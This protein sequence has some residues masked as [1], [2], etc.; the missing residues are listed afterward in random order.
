M[1]RIFDLT[2]SVVGLVLLSPFLLVI[3]V[4]IRCS[5]GAP[6]FFRQKRPG[7]KGKPFVIY[8]FRT[9]NDARDGAGKLL[10]DEKR[11]N[12]L[13]VLLRKTSLDE[14]PELFNVLWGEMSLVG[15]RP[16]KM[17]Y[18]E[19][20]SNEQSRRHDVKPGITGW[21]QINGRN[22]ISWES[23][24]ELDVWYVDHR[25]FLLDLR[26]LFNTAWI[27]LKREGISSPSHATMPSF[28]GSPKTPEKL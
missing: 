17:E 24:F 12:R 26:I 23:K 6:V 28:T 11:L 21:A 8:K 27:V 18:L 3:A 1:K 13:G 22:A 14:L 9:M 20:Y 25:T 16:L 4:A 19:L 5:M 10:P 7:L 15:P 2:V